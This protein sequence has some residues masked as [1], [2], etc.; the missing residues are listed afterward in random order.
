MRLSDPRIP[1]LASEDWTE[2]QAALLA[3]MTTPEGL[4]NIYATLGHKPEAA[5][6]FLTW[7]RYVLRQSSLS[8][9]QKELVILR[10]GWLCKSGYEFAQHS[11]LAKQAGL[12]GDDIEAIKT[13][14]ASPRWNDEQRTLLAAAD[15]LHANHHVADETWKSLSQWLP[16]EQLM[17]LVYVIGHYTQVCMILNAFGIQLENGQAPDPDLLRT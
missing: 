15:E 1:P 6:A 2:D 9:A 10:I 12:T 7:G 5:R 16:A 4:L 3:P 11:R 14:P 8:P 17:D 13:G